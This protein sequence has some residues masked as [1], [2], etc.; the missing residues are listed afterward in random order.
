MTTLVRDITLTANG[1]RHH[2]IA[3]GAQELPIVMM[4]HGLTQQAH[5]FD[6]I[7]AALAEKYHVYCLDVRG[8][9][10]SDWGPPDGYH[11]VNY[12]DDLEAVRQGL[13]IANFSLVGT[14]MG[15]L[16]SMHYTAKHP[17]RVNK[18]VLNDIGPEI[19]PAGLQRIIT[20]AGSAPEAFRDL[21]AVAKYYRTENAQVLANRNDDE[22]MEY[23]RWHV[24]LTDLG[25]YAWKMDAAVRTAVPPTV[26]QP[27][28]WESFK[29]IACPLLVIR[30]AKSDVLSSSIV[31]AMKEARPG[32]ES[33]EVPGVGHAQSRTEPE[34]KQALE[35]F[36]AR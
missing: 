9:G 29:S 25:T 30:G 31:A 4:I 27:D 8:R 17:D 35:A 28:P 19:D 7:A 6:A 12:V 20:M 26:P 15:G 5:V 32:I 10:E 23:A 33:V 13:G 18:V 34:A 2:V 22:V 3:R 14:S 1:V 16:I 36:L 11:M 24:R 21:N